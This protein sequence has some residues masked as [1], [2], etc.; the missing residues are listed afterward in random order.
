[1]FK[2]KSDDVE[3]QSLSLPLPEYHLK[4][5][6]KK[7]EFVGNQL[8]KIYYIIA[9]PFIPPLGMVPK[10]M[11]KE[12]S[13]E[14]KIAVNALDGSLAGISFEIINGDESYVNMAIVDSFKKIE[15]SEIPVLTRVPVELEDICP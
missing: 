4:G 13:I 12:G 3:C 10:T 5:T 9:P 15:E 1:M 8:C 14:L 6:F 11:L 7:Y 2:Q